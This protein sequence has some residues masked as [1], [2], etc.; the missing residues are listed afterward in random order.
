MNELNAAPESRKPRRKGEEGFTLLEVLIVCAIIGII[1]NI[2]IP[3]L[4]ASMYKAKAARIVEDYNTLR[5]TAHQYY[6]DYGHW[7]ADQGPGAEPPELLPYLGSRLNW[8]HEDYTYDWELWVDG[9]GNPTEFSSV[10]AS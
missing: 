3:G 1:A 8:N 5:L 4:Y 10:S 7:P 2:A 9:S 6:V